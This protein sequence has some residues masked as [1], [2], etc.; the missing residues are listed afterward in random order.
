M[1]IPARHLRV[2][3]PDTAAPTPPPDPEPAW[4]EGSG[5]GAPG[6]L[7]ALSLD[8]SMMGAVSHRPSSPVLVGR[9]ADLAAARHVLDEARAGQARVLLLGG[10]AGIGKSRLLGELLDGATGDGWTV[11]AGS[12]VDLGDGAPPFAPVADAVRRLRRTLGDERILDALCIDPGGL[13]TLLPGW[14]V[15]V[16]PGT[17]V[18]AGRVFEAVLELLDA[19]A[20]TGPV[21]FA[22]EDLHWADASTRDLLSFLSRNLADVPVAVV[23]TVRTDDLHRRH[24]LRPLLAELERLPRVERHDLGPLDEPAVAALLTNLAGRPPSPDALAAIYDRS[25]GNPFFAEELVLCDDSDA[26]VHLPESVRDGMLTRVT[27]LP[28]E[29]QAVLR[30]A[31]AVGRDVPDP[32]LLELT[33]LPRATLDGIVRDLL[34]ASL[35]VLDGDGYRFRH[36]LLQ[37]AVYDELLPAERV[38]LHARIAEHLAA[39]GAGVSAAELAHHWSEARRQPEAFTASVTAGLEAESRGA[40]SDAVAHYQ[41]ALELWDAVPDAAERSP[42]DRLGL[43][44]RA[45]MASSNVGRYDQALALHRSALATAEAAGDVHRAGWFQA[46]IAKDLYLDNQPGDEEAYVRAVE[47]VPAEPWTRERVFVLAGRAQVL[48]LT[49]RLRES[50]TLCEEALAGATALGERQLEGEIRNTL[51]TALA[52]NGDDRG[53]DE[54]RQALAIA[55]EVGHAEDIGRAYVNLTSALA[56]NGRWDE[57]FAVGAEGLAETRRRGI[58]RTHGAYLQTNLIDGLVATGRWDDAAAAQQSFA[59]RLPDSIISYFGVDPLFSDRGAFDE[60]AAAIE[61]SLDLPAEHTAVL[62][63]TAAVYEARVA[64]AVW[65][66]DLDAVPG[67]VEEVLTRLPAEMVSWKISPILWRAT[68]AAAD[69]AALARARGRTEEVDAARA[70]ADRYVERLEEV[71]AWTPGSLAARPVVGCTALLALA[72]A[73]RDRIDGTD[74]AEAW[75]AAAAEFDA[76]GIVYPAAYARYRAADAAIRASL[77]ARRAASAGGGDGSGA[78]NGGGPGAP[79][80]EPGGSGVPDAATLLAQAAATARSLGAQPL[81]GLVTQL[82]TRARIPVEPARA[83]AGA[84]ADEEAVDSGDDDGLGLSAREREVLA[85]VAAGRT[86]R[87]IGGEL[88]IS[89]KTASVHVSNILAK[90]GVAS[91][92]E[93][94]AVAHRLHLAS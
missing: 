9:D 11:M 87:Q 90:L 55:E 59:L 78:D 30:T 21:L 18:T 23:A 75:C 35:L 32:L 91:R 72:R 38:A 27:A 51:G 15:S 73:E 94:A 58:D 43:L 29:H 57:L 48:M 1:T 31:A 5:V 71:A 47:L 50:V 68:W 13:G 33:S 67:L 28:E 82:A 61:R 12:C 4:P 52:N 22:I 19:L 6:N 37:E 89:P 54:L 49:G 76:L 24:P 63:G 40:P 56:E 93:A 85:L 64:H 3:D 81:L 36:A 77:A 84:V 62:Q 80:A 17:P 14:A 34:G 44:D 16:D 60:A 70:L 39:S 74:T 88:F 20:E 92:V 25:E 65:T 86:N 7:A 53:F 10:D 69:Q 46:R 45:A 2:I 42:L 8:G 83:V 41:R 66:G 26:C 79:G